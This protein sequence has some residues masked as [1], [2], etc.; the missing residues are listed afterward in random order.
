MHVML[1]WIPPD[2]TY[3]ISPPKHRGLQLGDP[4]KVAKYIKAAIDQMEYHHI[5][6][7]VCQLY[8]KSGSDSWRIDHIT[9]YKKIDKIISE[10]MIHVDRT[11]LRRTTS[12]FEWSIHLAQAFQSVRYWKLRLKATTRYHGY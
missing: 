6:D 3:Q 2:N 8:D 10:S 11:L 9:D 1:T 4:R 7:K 5:Y 12:K